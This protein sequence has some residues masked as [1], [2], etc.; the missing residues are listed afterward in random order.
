MEPKARKLSGFNRTIVRNGRTKVHKNSPLI[1]TGLTLAMWA[2]LAPAAKAAERAWE[3]TLTPYIWTVSLDGEIGAQGRTTSV[4]AS[5]SDLLT[6][7][8]RTCSMSISRRM[9][10]PTTRRCMGSTS[11][12]ALPSSW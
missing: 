4:D 9:D 1:T 6:Y 5:F 8:D 11:D 2:V 12:W 3:Y 10:L 7:V